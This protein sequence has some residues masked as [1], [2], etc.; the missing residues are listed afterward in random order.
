MHATTYFLVV[1]QNSQQQQHPVLI[2]TN[3]WDKYQQIPLWQT[4]QCNTL[5]TESHEK[6]IIEMR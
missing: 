2:V 3:C 5:N 1:F 6:Q 4:A